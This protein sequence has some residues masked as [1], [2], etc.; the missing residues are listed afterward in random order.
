MNEIMMNNISNN[1]IGIKNSSSVNIIVKN[2]ISN[3][4]VDFEED[5]LTPVFK[6][7][8]F[9][10]SILI[11]F[12]YIQSSPTVLIARPTASFNAVMPRGSSGI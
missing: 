7:V 10:M 11:I 9:V 12:I 4:N 8:L 2:N 6:F 1:Y 5:D 3:N